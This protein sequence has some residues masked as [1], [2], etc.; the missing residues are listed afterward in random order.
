MRQSLC[1]ITWLCLLLLS[2]RLGAGAAAA[3]ALEPAGY[4][5]GGRFTAAV[6]DPER[7]GLLYVA[8]D[9]AGVFVSEDGGTSY[10][11]VGAGLGMPA[12]AGLA[13]PPGRVGHLA[14][15]AADGLY[16]S[17]DQGRTLRRISDKV[18][19]EARF[20]GSQPLVFA[21]DGSLLAA[22]DLEGV[23]RL[24][25]NGDPAQ[26]DTTWQEEPLFGLGGYKLN[27]L[28]LLQGELYAAGEGGVH[29]WAGDFW[30]PVTKGL[31]PGKRDITDLVALS[32]GVLVCVER[33]SG[34]YVLD[35]GKGLWEPLGPPPARI[36]G[37]APVLFKAVSAPGTPD[38]L[39]LA[40]HPEYWPNLLFKTSDLGKTWQLVTR[41]ALTSR[42][43]NWSKGLESVENLVFSPDGSTALLL[44][45]WN[46]WR[47]TDSGSSW[48]QVD[49]G[50]Q[51]TVVNDIA[52]HP[53]L[54]ERILLAVA[55]N[56]VMRSQDGGRSWQRAMQGVADGHAL[57]LA[58]APRDP[59]KLYL[60]MQPWHEAQ[61]RGT[62]QFQLYKSQDGGETWHHLPIPEQRRIFSEPFA[63]G[64]PHNVVI[65]PVN[66][67]L[68]YVAVN[69][70]G[71]YRVD[72][73]AKE[74][75]AVNIARNLERPFVKG[76]GA[77]LLHPETPGLLYAGVQD[78]GVYRTS[79]DGGSWEL[80]PGTRG[81][82][83]GLAMDPA[84]PRRLLAAAGGNRV[85]H[86]SDG[87]DSWRTLELP[88]AETPD[89]AVNAVAF[90]PGG[91]ILVGCAGF[92]NRGAQG[93]FVSADE[94]AS[95]APVSGG[96]AGVGITVLRTFPDGSGRVL[97]GYNGLGVFRFSPAP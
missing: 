14:V 27:S 68:I 76:P 95:F 85:L 22:S 25:A 24:T 97:V 28:A 74:P 77:L 92:N 61:D 32:Q 6:F 70:Y 46:V 66:D 96:T 54:P 87:G 59:Q 91:L 37:Q 23:F 45:W 4:G 64:L 57:A 71:I 42:N 56:G 16:Y 58:V 72:T 75:K 29:H 43:S 30:Q 17:A 69:G 80:L 20:C 1:L 33:N 3:H 82:I 88:F 34:A 60:F 52:L 94:G 39:F 81:Y 38:T 10:T 86:S 31:E 21:P 78:G 55:D 26:A 62:V 15:L 9:V 36:P 93:L 90:A 41:F 11:P 67:D 50:L 8:S 18:R 12:V 2:P 89:T 48:A 40:T 65:D 84:D 19:Y 13:V 73:A 83:F 7:P 44:D 63:D 79:N 49:E 53:Q 47:S 5:G 35:A 51:N